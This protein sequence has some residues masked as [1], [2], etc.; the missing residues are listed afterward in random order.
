MAEVPLRNGGVALISEESLSLVSGYRWYGVRRPK[1]YENALPYAF[2]FRSNTRP[3]YVQM[4]RLVIGAPSGVLVDHINGDT[5]DNRLENLR[6][7]SNSQNSH[8]RVR[9]QRSTSSRYHGVTWHKSS[10]KWQVS[11]GIRGQRCY[12]GLFSDE[13]TAAMAADLKSLEIFGEFARLN[14]PGAP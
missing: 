10:G 11:V 1:G 4:H 2:G 6:I 5:L 9:K 13:I 3:F 12:V 7:C 14:F 8:H